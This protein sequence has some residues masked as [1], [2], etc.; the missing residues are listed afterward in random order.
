MRAEFYSLLPPVRADLQELIQ[1]I[2]E[3]CFA[4]ATRVAQQQEAS[5][6]WLLPKEKDILSKVSCGSLTLVDDHTMPPC[7]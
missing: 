5:V 7:G 3:H 2:A 1:Q 6:E 4:P